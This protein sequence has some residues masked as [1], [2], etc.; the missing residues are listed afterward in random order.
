[1]AESSVALILIY[2]LIDPRTGCL[3]YIGQSKRVD[4]RF[5]RHCNPLSTDRSHRGCWLRGLHSANL[6]PELVEL[7]Y[8]NSLDEAA[9]VEGFWIASLRATGADLVNTTDG[10]RAPSRRG[11]KLTPE[12][13]AKIAAAH[14]GIRPNDGT[15]EKLRAARK[16]YRWSEET[17]AKFTATLT[18][19]ERQP[20]Q[21]THGTYAA[22]QHGCRCESCIKANRAYGKLYRKRKAAERPQ[23][24]APSHGTTTKYRNGCRCV[25]CKQA[26]V[27]SV[28]RR[29]K[30]RKAE[31]GTK[32]AA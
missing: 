1:M 20:K 4:K 8:V 23:R 27:Q 3:R 15:R 17:R 13:K 21:L 22:Y 30:A 31:E 29:K 9:I 14:I 18:T 12:H 7:E 32:I 24:L 6:A 5:W 26:A 11:Y 16:T 19:K 2:G 28:M 25:E 10:E